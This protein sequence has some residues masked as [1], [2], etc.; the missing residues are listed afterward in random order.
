MTE[1][2]IDWQLLG[3]RVHTARR[4]RGLTS[5]ELARLAGTTRVTISR[6]ENRKKPGVSFAILWRIAQVLQVSLDWLTG[7]KDDMGVS[8]VDEEEEEAHQAAL[9]AL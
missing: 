8:E 6:L 1:R 2:E 4:R 9:A 7:R 3:E 5:G